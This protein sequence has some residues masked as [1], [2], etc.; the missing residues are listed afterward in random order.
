MTKA[1]SAFD[2]TAHFGSDTRMSKAMIKFIRGR[3][4][5]IDECAS[6]DSLFKFDTLEAYQLVRSLMLDDSVNTKQWNAYARYMSV[7]KEMK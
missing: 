4:V 5:P 7:L 2:I 6:R 1:F 3:M